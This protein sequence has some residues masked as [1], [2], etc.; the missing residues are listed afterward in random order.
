MTKRRLYIALSALSLVLCVG[1]IGLWI[2]STSHGDVLYHGSIT[3]MQTI[4]SSHGQV[5]IEHSRWDGPPSRNLLLSGPRLGYHW[6]HD[7]EPWDDF[8][9]GRHL[10]WEM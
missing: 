6:F 5:K 3:A 7:P 9:R 2:R 1:T 4:I 8:G 10:V